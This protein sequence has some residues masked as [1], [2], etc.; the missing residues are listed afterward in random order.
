MT[1]MTQDDVECNLNCVLVATRKPSAL[2]QNGDAVISPR[3]QMKRYIK[4]H[5][6]VAMQLGN[7]CLHVCEPSIKPLMNSKE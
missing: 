1:Q 5:P 6:P 4:I 7:Q 3:A 2:T